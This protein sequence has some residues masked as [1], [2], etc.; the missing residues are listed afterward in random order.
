MPPTAGTLRVGRYFT[1]L[2]ALM[3]VLYAIVFWPGSNKTPKLG[4]DLEGGKQVVLQATANGKAPSKASM[5]LAQQI[6]TDRVN[7]LG[8][9]SAQVQIQGSDRI[10]VSVPG[11]NNKSLDSVGRAFQLQLRPLMIDPVAASSASTSPT[12]SAS[13]STG[14]TAK[15]SGSATS[16]PATSTGSTAKPATS[17]STSPSPA[18]RV[19]PLAA[20][21]TG[22][23]AKATASPSASSPTTSAASASPLATSSASS[24]STGADTSTRIIDIW[25]TYRKQFKT[26]PPKDAAAYAA[27]DS[28][29]QQFLQSMVAA[30]VCNPNVYPKDD[31][32][33]P[34]ITCDQ[35]GSAKYLLGSVIV[36]G[37]EIKSAQAVVDSTGI[38][39]VSLDFKPSG[40][41]KWADYTAKHNVN[42]GA[43]TA[44]PADQVADTLDSF[45]YQ[46]STIQS[47]IT[48]STQITG[49]FTDTQAKNL[50]NAL[51]YGALP[52]NFKTLTNTDISATLG[53]DQLKAG[54]LAGGIGLA[55]VII[56]S[57]FYY[58]ALGLVTIASLVVSGALTYAMLVIL[59]KQIDFT[60]T[61]AGIAGFIVAV[62]ITADSFVVFFERIKDEVH[63]GR[64]ARVA[65]PRAWD[66]ARRTILSA[67]FVSFLA[68]IILY[69]FAA[70]EVRGFAF[71]LGLSTIL[72]LI[73]VFLFTHPM[74]SL[75][76]R[77]AAFGSARFTGLNHARAGG[78]AR[79]EKPARQRRGADEL[80]AEEE[81]DQ[82]AD[83]LE[84]EVARHRA[85]A[86]ADVPTPTKARVVRGKPAAAHARPDIAEPE[87]DGD[88]PGAAD[89]DSVTVPKGRP[90]DEPT[91]TATT[92]AERAAA[93]RAAQRAQQNGEK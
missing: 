42:N 82:E 1:A 83:R 20:G 35:G 11:K 34:L 26:D 32:D 63:E 39:S 53:T 49:Q 17:S 23:P 65:I 24:S 29:H 10:V 36:K 56:Y 27:L 43:V 88:V 64:T 21:S 37:T 46:T 70:G 33:Q 57:L 12:A 25:A 90:A 93:R 92:A 86:G 78:I 89:G 62:G 50:A 59:G 51:K 58:R 52:L 54:L 87:P 28:T 19:V 80:T 5:Q 91:A 48:G 30:W 76:S 61:L 84:A 2:L 4:L 72:D 41:K 40:Q 22:T 66:R 60:L 75:F 74:V 38:W 14:S 18:G 3:A 85:R 79:Y 47:T 9:S 7:G 15:P 8:V 68:A 31:V 45:V 13:G 67:D 16:K 69:Y 6:I 73:V 44:T 71:T 55:L 81:L 77:S